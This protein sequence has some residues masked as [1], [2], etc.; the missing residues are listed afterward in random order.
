MCVKSLNFFIFYFF[1]VVK[2]AFSQL[3]SYNSLYNKNR[4]YKNDYAAL[5]NTAT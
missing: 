2:A 4:H 5:K 3:M 1:T